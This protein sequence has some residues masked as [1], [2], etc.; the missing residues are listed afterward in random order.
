LRT[1]QWLCWCRCCCRMRG[2]LPQMGGRAVNATEHLHRTCTCHSTLRVGVCR[3]EGFEGEEL[4]FLT[5]D[6]INN[7]LTMQRSCIGTRQRM[8]PGRKLW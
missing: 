3:R 2:A 8:G 4:W 1:L 6:I 7:N 5:P